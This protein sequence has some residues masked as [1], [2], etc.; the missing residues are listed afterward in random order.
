MGLPYR[1]GH[2]RCIVGITS[3]ADGR[4]NYYVLVA[5]EGDWAGRRIGYVLFRKTVAKSIDGVY[6]CGCWGFSV[7]GCGNH[8]V[9]RNALARIRWGDQQWLGACTARGVRN[10]LGREC[11]QRTDFQ[12]ANELGQA[13][14]DLSDNFSL[15]RTFHPQSHD[16]E[17]RVRGV[18]ATGSTQ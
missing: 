16:P 12:G 10:K 14:L 18:R 15:P 5:G 6:G 2:P 1:L 4:P 8:R 17:R 13:L 11:A 9:M 3:R 7:G